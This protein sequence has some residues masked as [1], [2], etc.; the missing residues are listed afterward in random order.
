MKDI[1]ERGF[2]RV[3]DVYFPPGSKEALSSFLKKKT[4][5]KIIRTGWIDDTRNIRNK[6][7]YNDP[8]I[9]LIKTELSIELWPEFFFS[10]ERL[11]RFDY[12]IPELKIGIEVNGGVWAKG[13]SGH[14]SG[15]GI[16]RDYEKSNL[17]QSL[18]WKVLTVVP[19]QI[20]NYEA[21][22]LLINLI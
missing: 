14:S 1:S 5:S 4:R 13:N 10:V 8:F 22:G 11:Y 20:K 17:A 19:S 18:G 2:V 21:L 9:N 12:A 7:K 15:K 6:E 16:M 3:G